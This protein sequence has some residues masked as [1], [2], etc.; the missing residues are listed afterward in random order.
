MHFL[1]HTAD[2]G[3]VFLNNGVIHFLKAEGIKSAFLHCGT[4]DAALYLGYFYLCHC[5]IVLN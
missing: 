1:N 4:V 5:V 3:N 2:R